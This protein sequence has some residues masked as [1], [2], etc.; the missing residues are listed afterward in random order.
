MATPDTPYAEL[1]AHSN[2]SFLDGASHPE[3]LV[4]VAALLGLPALA[5]TDHA[6]MY[7]AVRLWKA[8]RETSTDAAR[9]AGLR[10]VRPII[11]LEVAIPRDEGELRL[12][13]RGRKLN[14]P[15]R[16]EKASRG[17]PGELHAGPI[18]GDHLVLLAR[19]AAGYSALAHL[20]SRGHLAGEKQFPVFARTLVEAALDDARGHLL[21]LTGCRNGRGAAPP[22]GR[23]PCRRAG[24]RG[25]L[26]A[27]PPRRR[28]A[29]RAE[30]PPRARRRLARRPA[31]RAGGRG[32][33][34]DRGHQRGAPRHA[35]REAAPGRAGLHPPRCH[36]RRGAR[37]AAPQRRA[38]AEGR[39]RAGRHRPRAA[40]R[41]QPPRV[42]GGDGARGRHRWVVRAGPGLRALS[43][44]GLHGPRWRDAVLIS[45]PA[46]P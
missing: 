37:A 15:Y 18:P 22:A 9:E 16:G 10:P 45:L 33:P 7:G 8:A 13:R 21:A 14:D 17:W 20:A 24:S 46:C 19:D 12:A 39:R 3:E 30:P 5:I 4:G 11:G 23:R 29:G 42:G 31:R 25:T 38:R 6:G 34:A 2:F 1:H 41:A 28:P 26:G 40:R 27:P 44:S 35:R 32:R 43:V 36:P